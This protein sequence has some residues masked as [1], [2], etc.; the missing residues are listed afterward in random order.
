[1]ASKAKE[2]R[3]WDACNFLAV[4]NREPG[5]LEV[6]QAI[7]TEA[8]KPD[9]AL[10]IVTSLLTIAEVVRPKGCGALSAV[11]DVQIDAFFDN[12]WLI[13]VSADRYIM[14]QAR[15][16]QR[17]LGIK[18]RDSIHL[19]SALY[20]EAT[21]L[22]TY[23]GDF[24]DTCNGRVGNPPLLAREPYLGGQQPLFPAP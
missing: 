5:R 19:A 20:A 10:E 22:E 11:Q 15:Q 1:M 16:L 7:L 18:V 13:P 8:E 4:I 23:D 21:I 14:R 6:C 3:Y 17:D 9:S 24:A 12:A 2:R